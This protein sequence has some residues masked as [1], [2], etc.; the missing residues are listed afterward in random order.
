MPLHKLISAAA[1]W[2]RPTRI[3]AFLCNIRCQQIILE[4]PGHSCDF[5]SCVG[6]HA[7]PVK[8]NLILSPDNIT[9]ADRAVEPGSTLADYVLP[10][11]DFSKVKR[12]RRYIQ[13]RITVL[14]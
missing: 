9:V 11:P 5:T 8:N 1:V 7:A 13:Q 6:E 4:R 3:V 14:P 12:R 10:R 2:L